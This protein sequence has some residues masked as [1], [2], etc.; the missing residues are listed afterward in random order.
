ML[1][2]LQLRVQQCYKELDQAPYF[3][4]NIVG[5]SAWELT[6]SY[7]ALTCPQ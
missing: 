2:G 7:L 5:R 4:V 6:R 3:C 1:N